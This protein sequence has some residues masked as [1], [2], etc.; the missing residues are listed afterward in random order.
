MGLWPVRRPQR[1]PLLLHG[2]PRP[3]RG[4]CGGDPCR[5]RR[6]EL[7]KNTA[8]LRAV[9]LVHGKVD[10]FGAANKLSDDG[11]LAA[12]DP[13][14]K[15]VRIRGTE[16]TPSLRVTL[17]HELTHAV[18]DQHFD[19]ERT[20]ASDTGETAFR[21]LV[22]GDAM[23]IENHYIDELS[24]ADMAAYDKQNEADVK[25]ADMSDVPPVLTAFFDAPYALGSQLV[26]LLDAEG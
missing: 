7:D 19:L 20:F 10:L 5:R 9:G 3:L 18:Q 21:S 26:D 22:E 12:Y 8:L 14:D 15:H 4:C 6:E 2:L 1:L 25:Q 24:D 23:R 17:V 16:L 13:H 11:T